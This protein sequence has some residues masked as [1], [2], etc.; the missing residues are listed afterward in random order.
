MLCAK[1]HAQVCAC[2][3]VRELMPTIAERLQILRGDKSRRSFAN[4]LGIPPSTL[5]N[6]EQGD[7]SPPFETLELVCEKMFISR[8]WLM[9]GD[10]P[11]RH[12]ESPKTLTQPMPAPLGAPIEQVEQPACPRCAKLEEKLTLVEEERQRISAAFV[13]SMQRNL[14]LSEENGQLRLENLKM[15]QRLDTDKIMCQQYAKVI[16]KSGVPDPIF[17]ERQNIPFNESL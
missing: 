9:L 8:R 2:K 17:D 5:K 13:E 4:F 6:Y 7:T 14:Q 10:G 1:V 12:D 11:M 16:K 3:L 15:V